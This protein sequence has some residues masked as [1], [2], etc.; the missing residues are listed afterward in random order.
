MH[1]NEISARRLQ[2]LL[3]SLFHMS[4]H[5]YHGPINGS[6]DVQIDSLLDELS[7]T[8]KEDRDGAF[9]YTML[10]GGREGSKDQVRALL[11]SIPEDRDDY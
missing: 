6:P 9:V 10:M 5:L 11:A 4:T 7:E 2:S 1:D 3:L 8:K